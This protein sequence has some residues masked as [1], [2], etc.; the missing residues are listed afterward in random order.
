MLPNSEPVQ[1]K[2][3]LVSEVGEF[4]ITGNNLLKIVNSHYFSPPLQVPINIRLFRA[5]SLSPPVP[6]TLLTTSLRTLAR[7]SGIRIQLHHD[8]TSDEIRSDEVTFSTT[9]SMTSALLIHTRHQIY[10]NISFACSILKVKRLEK[11]ALQQP[12]SPL[13]HP[14]LFRRSA[15]LQFLSDMPKD[16]CLLLAAGTSPSVRHGARLLCEHVQILPGGGYRLGC[17][18][19]TGGGS[20]RA[21][22]VFVCIRRKARGMTPRMAVLHS[23]EVFLCSVCSPMAERDFHA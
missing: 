7:N 12:P 9:T 11:T 4:I 15:Y 19:T 23:L 13:P 10:E 17:W 1:L 2:S 21:H 18:A 6:L 5:S 22:A 14:T 8:N 16:I 20:R 3:S